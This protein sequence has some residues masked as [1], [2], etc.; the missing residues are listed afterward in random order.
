MPKTIPII[1]TNERILVKERD[2]EKFMAFDMPGIESEP[3]IPFYHKFAGKISECQYYFKEFIRNEYGK[4]ASKYVMAIIVPD[5][6]TALEHIFINEFFLHS[7]ACKAVAQTTMGQTL[8]NEHSKYIS[9]SRSCRNIILQYINNSEILAQRQYDTN[10]YD[11]KQIFEDAKRLHIDVEYANVPLYV[12]NF[13][14]NMDEFLDMGQ[15]IT[16]KE[17]LDKIANVDVEKA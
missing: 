10:D 5:D 3:N 1:I 17:F 16:M 6:T 14:L 13:N 11:A 7:D 8:S 9:I 4:K 12:N 15:E 2:S